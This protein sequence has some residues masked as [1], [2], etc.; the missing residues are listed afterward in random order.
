[1]TAYI[2]PDGNVRPYHTMNFSPGNIR[3]STFPEIWNN[4][5]YQN[6]RRLVK[7]RKHFPVCSKGCTERYR[8]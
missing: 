1:M 6:Y 8:Y 4:S 3:K 2:M 5:V 7:K